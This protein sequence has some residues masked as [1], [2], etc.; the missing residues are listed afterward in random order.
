MHLGTELLARVS[1]ALCWRLGYV[2][3]SVSHLSWSTCL[4][5]R[6]SIAVRLEYDPQ[7]L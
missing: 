6:H 3:M 5:N 2:P 7:C 1:Q 4:L